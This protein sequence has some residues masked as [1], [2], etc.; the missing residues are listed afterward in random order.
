VV[1]VRIKQHEW[2]PLLLIKY[3][4]VKFVYLTIFKLV[5]AVQWHLSVWSAYFEFVWLSCIDGAK[6]HK[7]YLLDLLDDIESRIMVGCTDLIPKKRNTV[8]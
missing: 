8:K 6:L 3:P 5:C 4:D 7:T 2:A 1:T